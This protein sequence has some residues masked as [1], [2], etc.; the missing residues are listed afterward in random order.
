MSY[1][2]N[3]DIRTGNRLGLWNG[4]LKWSICLNVR[5]NVWL[6]CWHGQSQ[7]WKKKKWMVHCARRGMVEYKGGVYFDFNTKKNHSNAKK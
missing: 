4:L 3:K 2:L 5:I 1:K 7:V 6:Q